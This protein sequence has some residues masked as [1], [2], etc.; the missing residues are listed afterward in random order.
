MRE[1]KAIGGAARAKALSPEVRSAIA[2]KAALARWGESLPKATHGSP[3]KPVRIGDIEIPCYVLPDETRVLSQ[4]GL[5]AALGISKGGG[6]GGERKITALM[7]RIERNGV[8][9]DDLVKRASSTIRF[10][11]PH[12]G[13]PADGYEATI[14]PDICSALIKADQKGVLDSRYKYLAER[15]AILQHGFATLGI[16]GLVDEATGYQNVRARDALQAFLDRFLRRELAAWVKTFPD[17][18]FEQL[19]RLKRWRWK[20]TSRRPG[21]VG[22]YINDLIYDRLGPG[23]LDELQRRNPVDANG[24]RKA[25]HFQWLTEDIGNPALA[26]H[27]YATIG[28]MRSHDDWEAFKTHF[29]RAFPKRG[30][31]LSLALDYQSDTKRP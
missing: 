28:F 27:M 12:G 8:Q 5:Y 3:D 31:N 26:Q 29:S 11:P 15:A 13:N 25:K 2:K 23:V 16:I 1:S 22:H 21:V 18:F 7:D 20:G 24:R 19:F 6:R 9:I 30:E 10:V 4:S 14:L 17:E